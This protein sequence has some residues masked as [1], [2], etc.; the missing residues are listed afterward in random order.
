[1]L[2]KLCKPEYSSQLKVENSMPHR[3]RSLSQSIFKFNDA[4]DFQRFQFYFKMTTDNIFLATIKIDISY[5]LT[6]VA[7]K[8]VVVNNLNNWTINAYT[9]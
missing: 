4:N 6:F 5:H 1:M 2:T 9:R 3:F 7:L 8:I